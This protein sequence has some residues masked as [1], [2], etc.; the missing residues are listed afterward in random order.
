M[1]PITAKQTKLIAFDLS[2]TDENCGYPVRRALRIAEELAEEASA[3]FITRAGLPI[4]D[5]YRCV[6]AATQRD[7]LSALSFLKPDLLIRDS[8]S[9]S[10]EEAEAVQK[11]VPSLLHFDDFGEGGQAADFVIQTLYGEFDTS[12]TDSY[13]TGIGT[14]LTDARAADLRRQR[15]K[16]TPGDPPRL[17]IAFGETDPGNLTFR[18]LRHV[19]NLQI[20]LSVTILL[21]TSYAHDASSLRMMALSRR[22]TAIKKAPHDFLSLAAEA[23][24]VL[25][26]GGYMPYDAAS[27]GVPCIILAQNP[28]ESELQFP[29][30]RDGFTHLG[31]GRKVKQSNLLNAIMEPLLHD[32]LRQRDIDRQLTLPLGEEADSVFETIRYLLDHPKR[33]VPGKPV[34]DVVN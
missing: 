4:P 6:Q 20:P 22:N 18:A 10:R 9:T 19:M 8:G 1:I 7:L 30:D 24:I 23:D 3:V 32:S 28:F 17:L 11:L 2:S 27:L 26:G 33:S 12:V 25:C 5:Q 13:K 16:Q 29:S 31:L 15:E 21:G 14:F 34:P